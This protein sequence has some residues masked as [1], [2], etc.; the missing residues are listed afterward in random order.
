MANTPCTHRALQSMIEIAEHYES[1][2][3][4]VGFVR[5]SD[6]V[7]RTFE[8]AKMLDIV[9]PEHMFNSTR[10]AVIE[11]GRVTSDD[12]AAASAAHTLGG[13]EEFDDEFDDDNQELH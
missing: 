13:D 1:R 8:R 11:L 4:R 3:I 9:P 10:E 2:G 5:V 6:K 7:R 12:G